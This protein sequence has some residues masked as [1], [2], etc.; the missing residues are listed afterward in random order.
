MVDA[1]FV[2]C[3]GVKLLEALPQE[4]NGSIVAA[5]LNGFNDFGMGREHCQTSRWSGWIGQEGAM[6]PDLP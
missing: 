3:T 1:G 5:M 2:T 6:T 4:G